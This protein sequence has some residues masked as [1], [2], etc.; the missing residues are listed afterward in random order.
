MVEFKGQAQQEMRASDELTAEG[1]AAF[2]HPVPYY[3]REAGMQHC[4]AMGLDTNKAVATIDRM[5]EAIRRDEPYQAM[6]AGMAHLDLTGTYRLLAVLCCAK[7][8]KS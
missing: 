8:G 6:Q 2:G 1:M 5:S 7:E 3:R 4:K